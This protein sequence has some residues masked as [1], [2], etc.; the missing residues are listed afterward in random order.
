M[1]YTL[2]FMIS[3]ND[4][5]SDSF[6]TEMCAVLSAL[7]GMD[8]SVAVEIRTNNEAIAKICE[9]EYTA[10]KSKDMYEEYKKLK[11]YYD[12]NVSVKY[13]SAEERDS[14]FEEVRKMAREGK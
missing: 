3:E 4:K 6:R 7:K 5:K 13:I 12:G 9:G 14:H 10:D 2:E 8:K 11:E 1:A